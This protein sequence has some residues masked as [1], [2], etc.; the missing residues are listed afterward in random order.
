MYKLLSFLFIS[1]AV[2]SC[3]K[4]EAEKPLS[5]SDHT[6]P[7]VTL[8]PL[9]DNSG[10][11]LGWNLSDEITY[12]LF[13][14][15][16]KPH[17]LQL[18]PLTQ[19]KHQIRR[20]KESQ[21]P[22]SNDLSWVKAHFPQEDFLVFLE[23]IEHS[24]V[25]NQKGQDLEARAVSANLHLAL[26]LRILDVRGQT[27]TVVLQEIVQD[28]HFIPKQFTQYNF[29]QAHWNT[30]DFAISPVG[31]AHAQLITEIKKHIEEYIT[32]SL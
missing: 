27:P 2:V 28:T 7:K 9:I 16:E 32:T 24:E 18:T 6:K 26:R 12:T 25:P 30:E 3:Q 20:L 14:K 29:Y 15:L 22:F 21:N 23:M 31:I 8:V 1:I 5:S 19:V 4:Q 17:T 10:H 13:S 11:S